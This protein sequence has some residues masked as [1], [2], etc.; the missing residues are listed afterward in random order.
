MSLCKL[1]LNKHKHNY[2]FILTECLM[3][4]CEL[5]LNKLMHVDV[6]KLRLLTNRNIALI[7]PL[8]IYICYAIYICCW[9]RVVNSNIFDCIFDCRPQRATGR[10]LAEYVSRVIMNPIVISDKRVCV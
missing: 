2:K 8:A 9:R 5:T 4:L 6:N 10:E 3:S 1:T 7:S